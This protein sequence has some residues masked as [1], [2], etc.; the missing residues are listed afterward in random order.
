MTASNPFN[1]IDPRLLRFPAN[2]TMLCTD[3]DFA[4]AADAASERMETY[5]NGTST[6][7]PQQRWAYDNYVYSQLPWDQRAPRAD[8][9]PAVVRQLNI[10]MAELAKAVPVR[11]Q[12]WYG[13]RR[14]MYDQRLAERPHGRVHEMESEMRWNGMPFPSRLACGREQVDSKTL[15]QIVQSVRD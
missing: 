14:P 2:K 13:H 7:P 11:T 4:A 1:F 15:W 12:S 5:F 6:A 10:H 9:V 8:R 3:A